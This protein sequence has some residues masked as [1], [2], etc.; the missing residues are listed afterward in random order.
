MKTIEFYP[1]TNIDEA[2]EALVRQAP[3]AAMF[4]GIRL[5]ARYATTSPRDIVAQFQRNLDEQHIRWTNSA[6]GKRSR[7]EQ[8]RRRQEAQALV[9]ACIEDL[10]GLDMGDPWSVLAWVDRM[11]GPA[12]HVDVTYDHE[13]VVRRFV[14]AGWKPGANCKPHFDGED[15][16]NFAGW[17]VGQW[18]ASRWPSVSSFIED[19]RAKFGPCDSEV[20]S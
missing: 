2:A 13:G 15:A 11:S 4:N 12:D 5:R 20:R 16:R 3:A 17:I 6:A 18:L 19:W 1:G 8:E 9:D 14:A 10:T 7:A